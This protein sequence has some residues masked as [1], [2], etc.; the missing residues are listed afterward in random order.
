MCTVSSVL[1]VV[2]TYIYYVAAISILKVPISFA[3]VYM[4]KIVRSSRGFAKPVLNFLYMTW[5]FAQYEMH[6]N[7]VPVQNLKN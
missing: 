5:V 4:S 2:V 3:D 1:L 6:S 7:P